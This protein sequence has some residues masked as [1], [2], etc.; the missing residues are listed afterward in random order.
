[1]RLVGFG[2]VWSGFT[3]SPLLPPLPTSQTLHP[4]PTFKAHRSRLVAF[5]CVLLRLVAFGCVWLL[6]II[7]TPPLTSIATILHTCQ[8]WRWMPHAC[9][10]IAPFGWVW[11]RPHVQRRQGAQHTY[12]PHALLLPVRCVIV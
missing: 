8:Q 1:M 12:S 10:V 2:C 9:L 7:T 4:C 11:L 5:G 3:I 6:N